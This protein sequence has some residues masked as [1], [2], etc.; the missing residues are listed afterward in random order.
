MTKLAEK[1]IG[2]MEE[3][4]QKYGSQYGAGSKFKLKEDGVVDAS[5]TADIKERVMKLQ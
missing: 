5:A 2:Y 3:Y 4:E 1:G